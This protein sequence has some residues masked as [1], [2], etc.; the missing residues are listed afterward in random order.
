MSSTSKRQRK[1]AVNLST[2]VRA[3]RGDD[4]Y[5]DLAAAQDAE[6]TTDIHIK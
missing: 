4:S 2:V 5:P 3:T 6:N 1:L